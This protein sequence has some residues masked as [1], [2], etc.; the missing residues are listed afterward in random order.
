M[1]GPPEK[2]RNQ[3]AS[4]YIG[5]LDDRANDALVWEL[6]LQ[7]GP[8]IN[9][10][11]PKDRITSTHQ[12]FG[13][14]EFQT[15]S[16]AEYA[17][18]IMNGIKLF[19][20]PVRVT[21]A[22]SDKKQINIGANIFIGNLDVNVDE[23]ILYETF[24]PFG[25][26]IGIPKLSRDATNNNVSKG[27]A[28]ISYDSFEAADAAIETM[29]GQF[30]FNKPLTMNYAFKKDGKG[31]ERHGT[32]AERL[33]AAQARKNNALPT[34]AAPPPRF[35]AQPPPPPPP[36]TQQPGY[37]A[38]YQQQ[39]QQQQQQPPPPPPPQ[40]NGYGHPPPPPAGYQQH[41]PPPPPPPP[42]GYQPT[43]AGFHPP[44]PPPPSGMPAYHY[45]GPP[46]PPPPQQQQP[47]YT[48]PPP[49]Q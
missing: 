37:Y 33:L 40:T 38:G 14:V 23:R 49:Q 27:Y 35:V 20:K 26:I 2:D 30:L 8:V 45:S 16:D 47:Y 29:N 10:H 22:S 11:L 9:V 28:F 25:N 31:G 48:G 4:C 42:A 34:A 15:E 41:M 13:F 36:P 1:S 18:K 5:N 7:A 17:C 24:I 21:K 6:M 44:P 39:Q 32:E 46:P 12:S 19:G 3:D 43:P